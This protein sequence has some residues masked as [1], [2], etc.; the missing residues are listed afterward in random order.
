MARLPLGTHGLY[1]PNIKVWNN[2]YAQ[3]REILIDGFKLEGS[4]EDLLFDNPK[5]ECIECGTSLVRVP[6]DVR[7]PY[8]MSAVIYCPRFE[9]VGHSKVG[10]VEV[11]PDGWSYMSPEKRMALSV[12]EKID[13]M[14]KHSDPRI[15]ECYGR[16]G[17]QISDEPK[18]MYVHRSR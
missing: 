7:N 8:F 1:V 12:D 18:P 9:H 14:F 2:F 15:R 6:T 3:V 13:L 10:W 17:V 5:A 11:W 4:V 16:F